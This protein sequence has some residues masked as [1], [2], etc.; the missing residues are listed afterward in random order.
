MASTTT[1]APRAPGSDRLRQLSLTQRILARPAAGALI[2]VVFVW[3]V[4]AVLSVARGNG[5]F[6]GLAGT[7]NYLDVAAQ[8]GV[9][10]TS[11]ALLM[12]AGE[13]DLS[14]GSM[15]GMS[16]T[17]AAP[18][19]VDRLVLA[20]T[21]AH[22]G[23]PDPWLERARVVRAHG[24]QAI[25]DGVVARWFTREL[26]EARPETVARFRAMLT[27]TPAPTLMS[28]PSS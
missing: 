4:F 1:A 6:L 20:C 9:I 2:I 23:P 7:L 5:A 14:I 12:I 18:A 19:R 26:A 17:L 11:V 13:F 16:L 22:L 15:V 8:I 28:R 27:A 10:A 3:I 21:S 24:L 25:A